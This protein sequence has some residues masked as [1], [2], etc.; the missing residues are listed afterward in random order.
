M[1]LIDFK[2]SKDMYNLCHASVRKEYSPNNDI[3]LKEL[4]IKISY[5]LQDNI[6]LISQQ[7]KVKL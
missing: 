4:F 6:V 1:T 5:P 2:I 3:V 7:I